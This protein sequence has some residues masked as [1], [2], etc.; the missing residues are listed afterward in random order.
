MIIKKLKIILVL[1]LSTLSS[2]SCSKDKTYNMDVIDLNINLN[3]ENGFSLELDKTSSKNSFSTF[4]VD[5]EFNHV[6]DDELTLTFSSN[7]EGYSNS[8]TFDPSDSQTTISLPYGNYDWE[9]ES[10]IVSGT[11]ISQKLPVY[12]QS[13]AS[14][15]IDQPDIDLSLIV[16]T[17]YSLVTVNTDHVSSVILKHNNQSLALESKDGFFYGYVYSGATSFTLEV[18]DNEGYKITEKLNTVES[19]KEYKYTLQYSYVNINSLVCLCEPFEVVEKFL[20]P[21]GETPYVLSNGIVAWYPFNGNPNDESGNQYDGINQGATLTTDRNNNLNK[22]YSFDG[23]NNWINFE[24]HPDLKISSSLSY[25]ALIYVEGMTNV[26]GI[27]GVGEATV[28]SKASAMLLVDRDYH[29][30]F[31]VGDGTLIKVIEYDEKVLAQNTWY[32]V[33]GSFN[34]DDGIIKLYLDGELVGSLDTDIES[35]LTDIPDSDN[36]FKIGVR[37]LY[38]SGYTYGWFKGKIDDIGIWNRV[39]SD[40]EVKWLYNN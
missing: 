39:L 22:A 3:L 1:L 19:C 25:S 4:K 40:C 37:D 5:S 35:L 13:D 30:R 8:L 7:P 34:S 12:G 15:T 9:I 24:D 38:S 20:T 16:Q 23:N 11:A 21:C 18:I 28:R 14:I 31:E 17:D 6:F 27:M 29:L 36:K 2:L 10:S 26:M 32:H 33:A